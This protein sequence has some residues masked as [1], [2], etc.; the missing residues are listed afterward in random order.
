MHVGWQLS[1]HLQHLSTPVTF[2]WPGPDCPHPLSG[3]QL[4]VQGFLMSSWLTRLPL[5]VS[6]PG[7]LP[8]CPHDTSYSFALSISFQSF[9]SLSFPTWSLVCFTDFPLF[10]FFSSLF[11]CQ[12]SSCLP[13][14]ASPL[15]MS[16]GP[17][18]CLPLFVF[19]CLYSLPCPPLPLLMA[20]L[21]SELLLTL[22]PVFPV[23]ARFCS[24]SLP[25]PHLGCPTLSSLLALPSSPSLP[26][27][28]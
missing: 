5:L 24:F 25:C 22:L 6:E 8:G 4:R 3:D 21:H 23:H 7:F 12:A 20:P 2:L 15:A 28:L 26:A 17:G 1:A 10:S 27:D 14:S 19:P 16:I 11:S 9:L 13:L 18:T